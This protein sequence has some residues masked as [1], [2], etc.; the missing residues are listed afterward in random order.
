MA[1][2]A[3]LGMDWHHVPYTAA[4]GQPMTAGWSGHAKP[5]KSTPVENTPP[6]DDGGMAWHSWIAQLPL[7]SPAAS[8]TVRAAAIVWERLLG[9][10]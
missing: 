1:V 6:S 3:G 5:L 9:L 2:I 10:L 4:P 8:I 7:L